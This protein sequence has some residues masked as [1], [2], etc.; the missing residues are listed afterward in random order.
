MYVHPCVVLGDVHH[1]DGLGDHRETGF[2]IDLA[3]H[4]RD[5]RVD[6]QVARVVHRDDLSPGGKLGKPRQVGVLAMAWP[7]D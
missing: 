3:H 2:L 6:G 7:S 4:G 5:L 1:G